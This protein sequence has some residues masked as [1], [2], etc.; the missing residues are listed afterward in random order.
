MKKIIIIVII[1][2]I[3]GGGW[4]FTNNSSTQNIV[5]N[6]S[7]P[8]NTTYFIN[9]KPYTLKEGLSEELVPNSS[10]KIVT[11]YFGNEVR[12]DL[13]DDGR[14]DIVFLITQ[15]TGGT[16]VFFYVVAA[17]NTDSGWKG[18]HALFLGDR[19]APQTTEL[20]RNTSYKNVIVVNYAERGS[21]EPMTAQPSIGK[22]IWLELNPET[23]LFNEVAS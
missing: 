3:V 22:S 11:K 19:I 6:S 5:E 13:N 20:S 16:G 1:V 21:N 10:S 12:T 4:Y 14:E 17:L 18:S 9:N 2:L 8:F 7:D 23:M 15:E